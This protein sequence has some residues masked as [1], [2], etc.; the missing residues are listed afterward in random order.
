LG[1]LAID[2]RLER[3]AQAHAERMLTG[4]FYDHMDPWNRGPR[5]RAREEGLLAASMAENLAKGL[6]DP[7][8]VVA[9]WM[10]SSGHRDNLLAAQLTR[11]GIGCAYD[12]S[13]KTEDVL[14]VQLFSDEPR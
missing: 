5:E 8:Q 14:W 2:A 6:F 1:R 13:G 11:I 3:A 4:H 7:R 10:G 9:N 12:A